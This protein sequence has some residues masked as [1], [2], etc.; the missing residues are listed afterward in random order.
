MKE[1]QATILIAVLALVT[2]FL[3]RMESKPEY[4]VPQMT[5]PVIGTMITIPNYPACDVKD[6]SCQ[7]G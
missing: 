5:E 1:Y 7:K 6:S 2:W 4:Q 3:L